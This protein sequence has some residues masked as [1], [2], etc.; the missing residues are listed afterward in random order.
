VWI[1]NHPGFAPDPNE[2]ST[3]A[4]RRQALR[5]RGNGIREIVSACCHFPG[6]HRI[7]SLRTIG[8]SGQFL[9]SGDRLVKDLDDAIEIG[10]QG[11]GSGCLRLKMMLMFHRTCFKMI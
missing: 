8:Y 5:K 7:S 1:A 11:S 4:P 10:N 9:L 6:M 3:S 2:S